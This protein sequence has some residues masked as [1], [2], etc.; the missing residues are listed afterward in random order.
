MRK[1]AVP[2]L[3][4]FAF[5]FWYSSREDA[6]TGLILGLLFISIFILRYVYTLRYYITHINWKQDG[7]ISISYLD[8][9][10]P[11]QLETSISKIVIYKGLLWAKFNRQPFLTLKGTVT[12]FEIRQ[13]TTGN[14]SEKTIDQLLLI[15]PIPAEYR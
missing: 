5:S 4:I 1:L 6:K 12:N 13:F 14:W 3:I 15:W 9:S 2:V 10:K 8:F 11:K 7:Q